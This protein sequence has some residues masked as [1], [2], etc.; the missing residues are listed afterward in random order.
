LRHAAL[1]NPFPV[2]RGETV[3][4]PPLNHHDR[5]DDGNEKQ[6]QANQ[7]APEQPAVQ[8]PVG[9]LGLTR[10]FPPVMDQRARPKKWPQDNAQS[11]SR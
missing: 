9:P 10:A 3:T 5:N 11:L 1:N 8:A 7:P 4:V 6:S 2:L